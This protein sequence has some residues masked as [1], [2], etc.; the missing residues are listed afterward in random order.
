MHQRAM[1]FRLA[2]T[3]ICALLAVAGCASDRIGRLPA[4]TPSGEVSRQFGRPT[5]VR[6]EPAGEVWEY[7]YGPAGVRTYMARFDKAGRLVEVQQVLDDA[8]FSQVTS[9]LTPEDVRKL[10]GRPGRV[11]DLPASSEQVWT[12]HYLEG[13]ARS[14]YFNVHFAARTGLVHQ[15]SRER[16]PAE[17]A[18]YFAIH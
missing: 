7:A 18:D 10:L 3:A 6:R 11:I 12:Y 8:H 4:G 2:A 9:G 5:E 1:G 17:S 13:A 16:D 14:M 15:T